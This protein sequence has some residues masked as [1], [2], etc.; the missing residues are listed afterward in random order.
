MSWNYDATLIQ[1]SELMKIRF[2]VQDT[3]E[4]DPLVQDE[5]IEFTL[6][7]VGSSNIYEAA[8]NLCHQIALKL[9]RELDNKGDVAWSSQEKYDH[10]K[11]LGTK[12]KELAT[13]QGG[14]IQLFAGGISESDKETYRSDDD[15][16]QPFFRRNTHRF[17]GGN[18]YINEENC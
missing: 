11:E 6:S 13:T 2:L 1:S 7:L 17:P 12:Y 5:E 8:H 3:D 14:S 15:I 16:V 10:Y 18:D 4:S 9:G